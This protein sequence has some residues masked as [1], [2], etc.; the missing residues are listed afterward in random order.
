MR[1]F[2]TIL[3][4]AVSGNASAGVAGKAPRYVEDVQCQ[5]GPFGLHLPMTLPQVMALGP[6]IRQVDGD[7]EQA[8]G[9][10]ATRRYVDFNGLALDLIVFSN[11]PDRYMLVYA[12]ASLPRWG[13]L[14][15]FPVGSPAAAVRAALGSHSKGDPSLRAT[16]GGDTDSMK[17]KVAKGK[18]V[19]VSYE[20][21]TG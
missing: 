15:P 21:Y 6:I 3:L 10:T 7:V 5:A 11:D 2:S 9:Y 16:Y 17:F 13:A 4:L 12:M 8:P 18:I 20:C 19:E 1:L 14:L